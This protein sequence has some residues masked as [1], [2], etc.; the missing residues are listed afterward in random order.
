MKNLEWTEEHFTSGGGGEPCRLL[1]TAKSGSILDKDNLM[2]T[3][4]AAFES[5]LGKAAI[6]QPVFNWWFWLS[7]TAKLIC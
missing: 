6:I 5:T 4:Q 2:A 1:I 7:Y 3:L